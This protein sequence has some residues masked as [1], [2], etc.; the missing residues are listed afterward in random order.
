[1]AERLGEIPEQSLGAR[2]DLLGQQAEV[3]RSLRMCNEDLLRFVDAPRH[4]QDLGEPESAQHERALFTAHAI[5][6][7]ISIDVVSFSELRPDP[8]DR[9]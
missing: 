6:G 5:I 1:M 2:L 3:I 8:L 9:P 4:R 7:T